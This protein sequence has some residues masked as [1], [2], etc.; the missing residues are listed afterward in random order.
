MENSEHEPAPHRGLTRVTAWTALWIVLAV[1]QVTQ[2]IWLNGGAGVPGGMSDGRFNQFVLEHG[3]LSLCGV[4]PLGSPGQFFPATGTLALSETHFGTLPLYATFRAVGLS[5]DR[6]WQG[7]FVV[8]AALNAFAA[9]RVLAALGVPRAWRGPAA[10]AATAAPAMVWTAGHHMQMLPLWPALFALDQVVRWSGDRATFRLPL[11][12]GW[13]AWQ[14]AASPY[15][16][17]FAAA[18]GTAVLVV[19]GIGGALRRET[20]ARPTDRPSRL[21]WAGALAVFLAGAGLALAAAANYLPAAGQGLAKPMTELA[22][23]APRVG[24]WFTASPSNL[25]CPT[26]RPGGETDLVEHAWLSGWLPWLLLPVALVWGWR[27]RR[28]G[29]AWVCALAAG[30]LWGFV[31]FTRWSERWPGLWLTLAAHCEPL[32]G[33]RG[34]GRTALL[35]HALQVFAAA[36]CLALWAARTR[37][38]RTKLW[39]LAG[40]TLLVAE[41]FASHQSATRFADTDARV[42]PLVAAWRAAGDKPVLLY[43]PG[44]TNQPADFLHLDAWGAALRLRRHTMNGYSG[45]AP[46][47]HQLFFFNP[48]PARARELIALT[49]VP[50]ND[51]S[52]VEDRGAAAERAIDLVRYAERP[53]AGLDDFALQAR[54]W[55]MDVAPVR[56]VVGEQVFYQFTPPSEVSFDLPDP[57]VAFDVLVTMR[58]GSWN[59]AGKSDGVTIAWALRDAGGAETELSREEINP[60]DRP[61]HRGV[62]S[63]SVALPPGV[64]RTLVL[65]TTSEPSGDNWWDWPLLGRLRVR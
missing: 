26:G 27:E 42:A 57:A 31:F 13:L 38:A 28:N 25:L 53:P 65:R 59:G 17:F 14:F 32:R 48:T 24:S 43:A 19:L 36:G 49:G 11:A 12:A 56:F 20:P 47:T 1:A 52:L 21:A 61:E 39:P 18:L 7:W 37:S 4:Y 34:A 44:Y 41:N 51:V 55:R 5:M 8:L 63:R 50:E 9:L 22:S 62:L 16:A 46:G 64:R 23:L 15:A 6:A 54:A 33:F 45:G 10:F 40:F 2:G 58:D 29:G 35:V 3:W 60:R 30:A